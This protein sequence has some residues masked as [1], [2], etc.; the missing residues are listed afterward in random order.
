MQNLLA[1]ALRSSRADHTEIRLERTWGTAI[2]FR[3]SRLEGA[4]TGLELGGMVRCLN[5]GRGWGITSF[6]GLEA[7]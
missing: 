5:R 2:A 3:G 4:A 6:T 1:D 7:L